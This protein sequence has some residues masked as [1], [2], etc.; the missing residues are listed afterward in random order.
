[1]PG[2]RITFL[3][4]MLI[5]MPAGSAVFSAEENAKE[6][7]APEP[8]RSHYFEQSGSQLDSLVDRV[9]FKIVYSWGKSGEYFRLACSSVTDSVPAKKRDVEAR[10]AIKKDE[11][12]EQ[13]KNAVRESTEQAVQ[14]L[15]EKGKEFRN[16]LDK[17]GAE[18]KNETVKE[19]RENADQL[20][21]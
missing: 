5:L 16:D 13:G 1:M 10:I 21:K 17:A 9:W 11:L 18:L 14:E 2:D 8:R 7:T 12:L 15:S 20:L 6:T 3:M 4:L 19:I